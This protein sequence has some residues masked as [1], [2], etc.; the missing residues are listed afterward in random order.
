MNLLI[1]DRIADRI[2]DQIS[3]PSKLTAAGGAM[4]RGSQV[5]R[6]R[7]S[8]PAEREH[9]GE[10]SARQTRASQCKDGCAK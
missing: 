1:V 9:T 8:Q 5:A 3:S 2:I 6:K 4:R 10:G 7:S